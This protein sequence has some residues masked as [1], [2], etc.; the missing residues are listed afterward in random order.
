MNSEIRYP[1]YD[2]SL[3]AL[4]ASVLKYYGVCDYGHTTLPEMD[5]L[6]E[7]RPDRVIVIVLSGMG[8]ASLNRHLSESDFLRRDKVC[9][10]SAVFPSSTAAAAATLRSGQSPLEH[11][12][13]GR[14]LYF[15][16]VDRNI[17]LFCNRVQG[18]RRKAADYN[19]P[20]KYI[21]YRTVSERIHEA[22]PSVETHELSRRTGERVRSFSQ[23][24]QRIRK[25]ASAPGRKYICLYWNE[26]DREMHTFGAA[27]GKA[28][29]RIRFLNR[30]IEKL[31][32]DLDDSLVAVTSDHGMIDTGWIYLEDYPNL[33]GLLERAPSVEPR[34]AALYVRPGRKL[35]FE[36]IFRELF[37]KQFLLLNREEILD[38]GLLGSGHPGEK[39]Y[40]VLGDYLAVAIGDVSL[41]WKRRKREKE[42]IG[43]HS[44]LTAE[45][46]TVPFIA[47]TGKK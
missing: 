45:E 6:L 32:G 31:A 11:S 1:D 36:E 37:G 26:P 4:T 20:M 2:R 43:N 47:C 39:T 10:L 34:A 41:G 16:E 24:M 28:H 7:V 5:S 46:M 27:S 25:I 44:G 30:E 21:P 19:V 9:D 29:S 17:S 8:T 35:E 13:L 33:A 22:D 38:R 12:W 23:A 15:P 14:D 3:L 18:T 40:D 42:K